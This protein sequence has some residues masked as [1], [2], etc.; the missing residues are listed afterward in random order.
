MNI[1]ELIT[2]YKKRAEKKFELVS[3]HYAK[4]NQTEIDISN[5][6][7]IPVAYR[8]QDYKKELQNKIEMLKCHTHL[9]TVYGTEHAMLRDILRDFE[10]LD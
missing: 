1:S 6:K 7:S 2:L 5:L 10:K 4:K 3:E 9:Y 8:E